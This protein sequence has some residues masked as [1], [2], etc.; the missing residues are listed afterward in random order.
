MWLKN[1]IAPVLDIMIVVGTIA[2]AFF[3]LSGVIP[4]GSKEVVMYLLGGLMAL[5]GTVYNYHRGSSK[6]SDK[7]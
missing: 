4:D 7:I 5:V 1:N 6:D 2:F 3:I